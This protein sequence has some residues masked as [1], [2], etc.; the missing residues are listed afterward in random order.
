MT[1]IEKPK[2]A[3]HL[4][5]RY[6]K[7]TDDKGYVFVISYDGSAHSFEGDELMLKLVLAAAGQ[8]S[9]QALVKKISDQGYPL[10][11]VNQTL[12]MLGYFGVIISGDYQMND[13]QASFWLHYPNITPIYAQN[14]LKKKRFQLVN[15]S[16]HD[17]SAGLLTQQLQ[18]FGLQESDTLEQN[19][20]M[21]VLVDDYLQS[22]IVAINQQFI[23]NKQHWILASLSGK[24]PMFGPIFN[25]SS[26]EN[27]FCH[28]CL[29]KRIRE[30]RQVENTMGKYQKGAE[31]ITPNFVEQGAVQS[32]AYQLAVEIAKFVVLGQSQLSNTIH[33]F[34]WHDN[35]AKS[36][37]VSKL[38]QCE[39]CGTPLKKDR[40]ILPF[41]FDKVSETIRTSGGYR[42][43]NPETTLN[44]Y[45][46][47]VSPISGVVSRLSLQSNPDD[48]WM[49]VYESGNNIALQSDNVHLSLTSM[50]MLNAGK[51][52]SHAQAKVSALAESIERYCTAFQGD[53][54][55][56][57]AKF[58]DFK[59]GEAILPNVFVHYSDKQY[60]NAHSVNQ[61]MSLFHHIPK[62][63]DQNTQ[64]EW[65][66]IWSL[67]DDKAV[68]VPTQLLYFG[69]PYGYNWV[70]SADTNGVASGTSKSDAFVQ[71]FFELIERDNIAIWW[72]NRL[73]YSEVD[74]SSFIHPYIQSASNRYKNH[75]QRKLWAIDITT[76]TDIPT[77][78]VVSYRIDKLGGEIVFAAASHFDAEIAMLRAVCEHNQ[79][80]AMIEQYNQPHKQ[81]LSH[82][83]TYWLQ[84]ANIN[85]QD[86]QFL[87]PDDSPIKTIQSYKDCS[88]LSINEQKQRCIETVKENNWQI[89]VAELTRVDIEMPVIKV[90]I[91]QLRSMHTRL[92]PGRLYEVPVQMGK[93]KK[94]YQES[95]MN[96]IDI[97]I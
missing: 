35:N 36:H 87:I 9:H 18:S 39:A 63:I 78:I 74:L 75:Y 81:K 95:E 13:S 71:A 44:K 54:I 22:E 64:Y 30:N 55:R 62:P 65:S 76:D 91:P 41:K 3:P 80:L 6:F 72:F 19:T 40:K 67:L 42:A 96:P 7:N 82:E 84:N 34:A 90:L 11:K 77:F 94:P 93:L 83:F 79:L 26:Q 92:D 69:Y 16:K 46:Y 25:T 10:D 37:T 58:T 51:G 85:H 88:Q 32:I 66:P 49:F 12:G 2:L 52:T 38:P 21:I 61:E 31:L 97:F 48:D 45:Q 56:K 17:E 86:Y 27:S 20:I 68:W 1:I 59:E 70:A 50:R 89:Y 47:L 73:Q 53:E 57:T 4:Y 43:K 14:K 29:Y 23:Q 33:Q 8:L 15:H 24:N 60:D 28:Q 5:L